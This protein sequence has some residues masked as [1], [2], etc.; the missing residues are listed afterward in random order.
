MDF[1]DRN[2]NIS[3][4]DA[5]ELGFMRDSY[6]F[7]GPN[8]THICEF[9]PP[10]QSTVFLC[11]TG[12]FVEHKDYDMSSHY[13][14]IEAPKG[15]PMRQAFEIGDL[16]WEDFWHH[17]GWLIEATF[18]SIRSEG[19]H[20]RYVHPAFMSKSGKETIEEFSGKSPIQL[21]YEGL[22]LMKEMNRLSKNQA[23]Q[24]EELERKFFDVLKAAA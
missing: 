1:R 14:L 13:Y 2:P 20:V 22:C 24:L 21:K 23:S 19:Y 3:Y 11:L 6:P 15:C 4:W 18:K 8:T 12:G 10:D 9:L 5:G 7:D 17:K 16:S